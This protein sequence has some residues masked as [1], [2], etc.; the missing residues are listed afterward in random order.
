MHG[1][2][3]I[4][5]IAEKNDAAQKIANLLGETKEE[6]DCVYKTPIFRFKWK[7]RD[8]VSIGLR[9]HIMQINFPGELGFRKSKGWY[10]QCDDGSQIKANIPDKLAKPPFLNVR[11]PFSKNGVNIKT[12][13][14][15]SLEYFTYA[16]TVLLPKEKE[17]IRSLKNLAK[18]ADEIIIATDFDREGELIGADAMGICLEENSD[19]QYYRS[20]FSAFTKAEITKSFVNLTSLDRNLANAGESRREIDLIWGANITRFLTVVKYSAHGSTRSSGR[21]QGPA[22]GLICKK[23]LERQAFV[24]EKFWKIRGFFDY[25]NKQGA[26]FSGLSDLGFFQLNAAG[27]DPDGLK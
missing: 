8:C 27:E 9:G 1:D 21:V 11:S 17:I 24:P 20:R 2:K 10:G 7:S 13:K 12:W 22:L 18:K 5:V 15:E 19:A 26:G 6:K 16:P 4:L 14:I 25:G 23:E 3:M